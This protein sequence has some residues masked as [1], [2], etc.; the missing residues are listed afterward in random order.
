MY[1]FMYGG[2]KTFFDKFTR[3]FMSGESIRGRFLLLRALYIFFSLFLIVIL[4]EAEEQYEKARVKCGY[5]LNAHLNELY[6]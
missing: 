2:M 3:E 4:R 5:N 6:I 1:I